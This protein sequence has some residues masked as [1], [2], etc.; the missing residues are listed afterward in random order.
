MKV[1]LTINGP[2]VDGMMN[3]DPLSSDGGKIKADLSNLDDYVDK[4]EVTE[5]RVS[6]VLD[7]IMPEQLG[8]VLTYWISL[9]A[10][11]GKITLDGVDA[12]E[13]A[14]ALTYGNIDLNQYNALLHGNVPQ[15]SISLALP[16]V[17]D[18][19]KQQGLRISRKTLN[20]FRYLVE[21]T[22]Q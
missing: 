18:M 4:A 6:D 5:L 15:R 17:V 11:G 13:V 7:F 2:S 9:L 3:F 10:H 14:H 12:L 19:L 16:V 21:A 22:R 8:K 20:E 1:N